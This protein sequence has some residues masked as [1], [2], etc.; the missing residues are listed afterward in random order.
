MDRLALV[1]GGAGFIGSH[2]VDRLLQGGWNVRV[3]DNLSSGCR[4]NLHPALSSI[5]LMEGDI[6]DASVC[7]RA[8][9]GVDCLFHLAAMVSVVG[10]IENPLLSHEVNLG[11]TLNLLTA[12]RDRE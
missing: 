12:G 3:L 11:G 1:T 7:Y 2:V 4:E 9:D 5:Q 10:S 6:R 8:C